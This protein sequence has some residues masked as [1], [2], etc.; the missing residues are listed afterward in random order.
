[1]SRG[2][3]QLGPFGALHLA[4]ER[5]DHA[6]IRRLVGAGADVNQHARTQAIQ[7]V[8]MIDW[9]RQLGLRRRQIEISI[10]PLMGAAGSDAGAS[11]ETVRLLLELG[12]DVTATASDGR[13]ALSFAAGG[14]VR[15]DDEGPSGGDTA[16]LRLL[17]EAAGL[18]QVQAQEPPLLREAI[19]SRDTSRIELLLSYGVY[20]DVLPIHTMPVASLPGWRVIDDLGS[21]PL[22]WAVCG[23][24]ESVVRT[25]LANGAD[26]RISDA[27]YQT[28]LFVVASAGA[29]R[30]LSEAGL[31]P[32][33]ALRKGRTPLIDA[34]D[35]GD[36]PRVEALLAAGADPNVANDDGYTLLMRAA[37]SMARDVAVLRS[38][39]EHGADPHAVSRFGYNAFHA[40]IDINGFEANQPECVRSIL[41]YLHEL[42]VDLEQRNHRCMTPRDRAA[43]L[44]TALE[45]QAIDELR[46]KPSRP[47]RRG[48]PARRR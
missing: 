1:M 25:L 47:P 29:A 43:M 35:E 45:R 14:L 23:G 5:G 22:A 40:A 30:A 10:T 18:E 17:L 16:R 6:S 33:L 8:D 12:A 2:I 11:E 4:A 31:P 41:G 32:D 21:A 15:D 3:P 9:R 7:G 39:V 44:G 26:V 46:N 28:L 38:L 48:H 36:S 13:T 20:P 27:G 19:L 42:G 34:I 24:D 37:G